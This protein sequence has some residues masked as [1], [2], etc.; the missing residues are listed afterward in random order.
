MVT[1]LL[2]EAQ[3]NAK[4]T[5]LQEKEFSPA[6]LLQ[7][8][9][10][11]LAVNAQYK[12]IR[13]QIVYDEQIPAKLYADSHRLRQ[14]IVN[15]VGNAIKFTHEGQVK[16]SMHKVDDKHWKIEVADTGIGIPQDA[17][18][19]IFEPFTQAQNA[20]THENAGIGLGLSITKQ[21]VDLMGGRIRLKSKA[22]V[23]S[24][25]TVLLPMRLAP[26]TQS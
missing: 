11:G 19:N 18:K 14:I 25:F 8:A 20:I 3:A 22:G 10:A 13:L 15:L 23:G 21:L 7:Q 26:K 1:E 4:T 2:D 16:I 17:Q 5:V 6:D 9:T 12:G 24:T